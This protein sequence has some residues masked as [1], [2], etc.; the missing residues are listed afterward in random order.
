MASGKSE[1]TRIF[2]SLGARMFDADVAARKAVRKGSPAYRAIIKIFG[3]EYLKP[4]GELNRKKLAERVFRNP[5]DLHKLNVLIHPG[6]IFEMFRQI[7]RY[8]RRKGILVMD[9]PLR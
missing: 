2:K 7:R 4:N 9:V 8:R 1:V 6:V 3:K 5:G